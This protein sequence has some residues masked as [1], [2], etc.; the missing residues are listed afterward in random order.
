VT[1]CNGDEDDEPRR[2]AEEAPPATQTQAQTDR[3][4]RRVRPAAQPQVSTVASG[5]EI[6]WEIA[7]L[8]DGR[9]LVTERP[10]RVRLISSGGRLREEPVA[11]VE[12]DP[13]GEG[14][15]LGM[16]VDPRFERNRFV[17]L[18]RTTGSGNEVLRYRLAGARLMQDARILDGLQ[19][20]P[21]HDGGRI[22]FGPDGLLY[23]STGEAGNPPLAQ[24]RGSLNGK[25][26]RLRDPRGSGRPEIVS[27]GHRNVQ[28]FDWQPG[29]GRLIATE[30]GPESDDEVNL[31]RRG[32]NYG[33][34]EAQGDEGAPQFVEP[35]ANYEGVIA[36]SGATFV[37]ARGSAWTGS[38]L[39]GALMG[40]HIRKLRLQGARVTGDERLFEGRF[41]RVRTVVQGPD[42]AL[43]ALT[44]NRDGRGSP[45][46]RDDRVLRIVPPG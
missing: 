18:Y 28:G 19:S 2:R 8:P 1:G 43:Y 11:Q 38:Y 23:V 27:L 39:F 6:P 4:E 21:I 24:D 10:G 30:F 3:T 22:H 42:G 31:I 32:G 25:F 40:E 13:T 46:R 44:S 14:G 12:V 15:L 26:L 41:G 29:S 34:P 20:G 16:A 17:Y 7:F 37:T 35:I 9:A 36:P 33:W 45:G 5:L